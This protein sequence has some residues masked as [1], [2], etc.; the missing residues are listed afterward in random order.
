MALGPA[1]DIPDSAASR[2]PVQRCLMVDLNVADD[3]NNWHGALLSRLPVS[4][5]GAKATFWV[6][7]YPGLLAAMQCTP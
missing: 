3:L 7:G 5:A 1:P 2:R 4:P 6:S